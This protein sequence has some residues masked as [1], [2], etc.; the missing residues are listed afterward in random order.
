MPMGLTI[1]GK[2]Y[3]LLS[4]R[5]WEASRHG[6]MAW[7]YQTYSA[8]YRAAVIATL[9]SVAA[10][11]GQELLKKG[12]MLMVTEQRARA[13]ED[14]LAVANGVILDCDRAHRKAVRRS[15]RW[16]LWAYIASGVSVALGVAVAMK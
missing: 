6:L 7:E 9:D 16:R 11:R 13:C 3:Y 15:H 5:T 14:S 10:L 8:S 12:R 4:E 2:G 1:D